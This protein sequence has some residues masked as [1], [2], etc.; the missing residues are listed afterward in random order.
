MHA[1]YGH[2]IVAVVLHQDSVYYPLLKNVCLKDMTD[3]SALSLCTS[4]PCFL[5]NYCSH[6][7]RPVLGLSGSLKKIVLTLKL[8]LHN[9]FLIMA[10]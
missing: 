9:V 8:Q 10:L 7:K 3:R 4:H 5:N 6:Y 2:A 1:R